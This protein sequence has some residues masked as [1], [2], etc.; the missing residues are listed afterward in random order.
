MHWLLMVAALQ[1]P[2]DTMRLTLEAAVEQTRTVSEEI[3]L[4]RAQVLDAHGQVR[5]AFS[6]ALP[7][8]TGSLVYTRQFASIFQGLAGDTTLSPIFANS[9]FGAANQWNFQIEAR[10]TLW[11][12]GKVGA[13][14]VA[15]RAFRRGAEAQ[16]QEAEADLVF[17]VKQA[18]LEAVTAHR[19]YEV[20]AANL[21]LAREQLRRV[22]L[23]HQAGTRAEYD[24][25]RARVDAA[26][27]EPAVVAARNSYDIALIELRRLVNLPAA[28]PVVLATP[29][30]A[31]D[32]TI[33]VVADSALA[34]V[35]RA[36]LAAAEASVTVQE[37]VAKA[38]RSDRL[39]TLSLGTTF[40]E[41]AFPEDG[42]PFGTDFRRNWNAEVR[43]SFPIFLGFRTSGA[44]QRAVA[45]VER[46]RAQRDQLV[47]QVDL[48]VARA[49]AELER[50]YVLMGARRETVRQ[51]ERAHHLA[52]VRYA[53]GLTT[54]LEVSDARVLRQQAEVNEI[55]AMRDYLLSLAALERALGRPV[56]VERRPLDAAAR[57]PISEGSEQ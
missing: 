42:S 54:Q 27:Q 12:G 1:A 15:A 35:G 47:E 45:G 8:V 38:A 24:L 44:V 11:S 18:Y 19:L 55:E 53:N 43:L 25:L 30:A 13:G 31:E 22:Q 6:A 10:Q 32:G 48:D 52:G 9:P 57:Y 37:Q 28:Q 20:A 29:L 33:P 50:T 51:A 36:A 21:A 2:P 7:Q 14:L 3:R 23:Y 4:A 56:S 41:Q 16:A 40:Q 39:P 46:A 49:R 17:R 5:E 26:N 34:P